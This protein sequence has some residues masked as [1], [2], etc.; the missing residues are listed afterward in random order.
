MTTQR[1][2]LPIYNLG[3][4]GGGSL[5][6][7]RALTKTPGVMQAYVNPATEMA[8]VVYDP[9]LAKEEQFAAVIER[10]GYGPPPVATYRAVSVPQLHSASRGRRRSNVRGLATAA[11]LALAAIYALSVMVEVLFPNQLK[12]YHLW[13]R[14]LLGVSWA[15]PWTLLLGLVEAFLY[16]AIVAWAFAVLYRALPVPAPQ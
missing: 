14:I 7:E 5:M 13:E 2:T 10:I 16:G 1:I 11:G 3:C 6:I 12:I 8:Y 15:M 9:T 4:G